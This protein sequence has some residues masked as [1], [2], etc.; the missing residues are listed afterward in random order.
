MTRRRFLSSV[1]LGS[2]A[3]LLIARPAN[4]TVTAARRGGTLICGWE[5]EPGA[6]DN[7]IDRGAVSRTLLH[8][9]YDRLVDRNMTVK[10]NQPLVGN[11]ATSWEISPA[12]LSPLMRSP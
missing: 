4:A 8:N 6:F 1:A 3:A 5:A 2:S 7:D 11:L 12:T 9:I 10:A